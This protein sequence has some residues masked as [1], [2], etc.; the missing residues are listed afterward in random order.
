VTLRAYRWELRKLVSQKRTFLGLGAVVIIPALF[1]FALILSPPREGAGEQFFFRYVTET[2]WAVPL[3]LLVFSSIWFFPL[4]T[5]LVSGDIV[6][7]EDQ[8]R[9]LKTVLT[10]S[11]TRTSLFAAKVLAAFTYTLLALLLFGLTST[12]GGGIASGFGELPTF[13]SV[14][15]SQ[16]AAV[17]VGASFAVYSLPVLAIACIGVML[18]TLAK[19]SAGAVVGTLMISLAM[20]L[21]RIIPGLDGDGV[22]RLMLTQQL[23]A[24][25]SL[26]RDPIDWSPIVHATWVSAVYAAV[27]LVIAWLHFLRRDVVA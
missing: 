2:G 13:T 22:Q 23:N 12:I 11:T 5:A 18:S 24:W 14:I 16:R 6:A 7:A 4:V 1:V 3:I 27:A 9:T 21:T 19:N 26:F 25:Q 10:R 8:N 15:S 17:L 20:Q